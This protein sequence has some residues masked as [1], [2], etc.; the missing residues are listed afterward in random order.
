M[1]GGHLV[2]GAAPPAPATPWSADG[3]GCGS[4]PCGSEA[5][6]RATSKIA[7]AIAVHGGG[8]DSGASVVTTTP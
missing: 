3:A 1:P 6:R 4:G 8:G 5:P 7:V 2:K